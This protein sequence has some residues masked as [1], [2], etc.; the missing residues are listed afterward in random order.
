VTGSLPDQ[1]GGQ[2]DGRPDPDAWQTV[3]AWREVEIELARG[4]D[5]LLDAAGRVLLDAGARPSPAA[6]KLSL[7]LSAA[8]PQG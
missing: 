6:S 5:G 2:T 8:G 3:I 1:A 4:P 7:L